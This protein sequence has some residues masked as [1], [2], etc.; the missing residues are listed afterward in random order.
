MNILM[1]GGTGLIGRAFI[2]HHGDYAYTVLTR[3]RQPA[4]TSANVSLIHS[5]EHLQ[6]LDE[7][8]AVINLAGEPI[9]GKRWTARQKEVIRQSRWHTTQRL[10]DLIA[11]SQS[12]P[13]V[14]LSGSAIGVYG[15]RGDTLLDESAAVGGSDFA[16]SLC[17]RWEALARDAEPFTR[18]V[19]LRTGIVLDTRGGAL[20]K[21]QLPFKFGMGGRIGHGRQYMSWI[22]WLDQIE[23][24]NFLLT[25]EGLSGPVNL[26]APGAVTN[27]DYTLG[28]AKA[29]HRPAV[30]PMPEPLVKTLFGEAGSL[31]LDSQRVVPKKLL[32]S[33]FQFAFDRL[34]AALE[35][36][37]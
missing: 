30:L 7:Y 6:H 17:V 16:S 10:V 23:A 33:G 4:P 20:R 29:L 36:L 37:L 11:Q 35:D 8:D 1:T 12:P 18:V 32:E 34:P 3:S 5:L 27:A 15:N 19:L 2:E 9:L 22:H 14:F 13:R 26:V 28:L 31:L 21:M 25:R 24:M